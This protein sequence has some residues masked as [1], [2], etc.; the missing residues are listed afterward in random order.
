MQR[1]NRWQMAGKAF[2]PAVEMSVEAIYAAL[3]QTEVGRYL[4]IFFIYKSTREALI[5]SVRDM[6]KKERRQYERR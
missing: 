3:G 5:L 2:S 6:N 4:V 1:K